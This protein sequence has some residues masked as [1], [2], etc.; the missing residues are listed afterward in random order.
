MLCGAHR[1][2][3]FDRQKRSN[4]PP[5]LLQVLVDYGELRLLVGSYDLGGL[6][7]R[8]LEKRTPSPMTPSDRK[9]IPAFSSA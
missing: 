6:V 2:Q 5:F 3:E 4:P 9:T 8:G 7:G 1:T